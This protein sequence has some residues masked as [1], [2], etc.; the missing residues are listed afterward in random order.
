MRTP[1]SALAIERA[2]AELKAL[3]AAEAELS[4]ALRAAPGDGDLQTALSRIVLQR[5]AL[6][7]L[8]K[9]FES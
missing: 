8:I 6:E 3:D 2:D 5:K 4:A 9:E 7:A 1:S